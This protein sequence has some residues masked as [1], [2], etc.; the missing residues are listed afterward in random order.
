MTVHHV[1]DASLYNYIISLYGKDGAILC[2][3]FDQD[4]LPRDSNIVNISSVVDFTGYAFRDRKFDTVV[5]ANNFHV[6]EDIPF[7]N[8][9]LQ[10]V[11]ADGN[12]VVAY[13]EFEKTNKF[14]KGLHTIF[15]KY[16]PLYLERITKRNESY[17]NNVRSILKSKNSMSFTNDTVVDNED[18]YIDFIS[19]RPFDCSQ[20]RR[21][22]QSDIRILMHEH[23]NTNDAVIPV[24]TK[25]TEFTKIN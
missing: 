4:I 25:I 13:N 15:N 16:N 1:L 11:K 8:R 14:I 23:F 5:V 6:F 20:L 18:L 19:H 12:I 7:F 21:E 2:L 17:N 10:M 3:D 24:V 22:F 9:V